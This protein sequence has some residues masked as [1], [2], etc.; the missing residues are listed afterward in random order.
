L[1]LVGCAAS[2]EAENR[3]LAMEA[4]IDEILSYELDPEEFGE[5]QRCLS[6]N[7]YRNYRPLGDRH[8]L[9][10][11]RGDKLWINTLRSRCPDLRHGDFLV[12]KSFSPR[13]LCESDRFELAEWFRMSTGAT[14]SLGKFK[15]VALAQVEEIEARLEAR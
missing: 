13:R 15:P 3:R 9:F 10:E 12:V 2:P 7:Q 11:G 1:L 14:C 4:D 6:E 8:L 5:P